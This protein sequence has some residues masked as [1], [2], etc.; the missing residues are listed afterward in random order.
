MKKILPLLILAILQY[1]CSEQKKIARFVKKNGPKQI[2]AHIAKEYPEYLKADTVRYIDTVITTRVVKVPQVYHDTIIQS[3][4]IN[5]CR[6][7]H[8]SDRNLLFNV[9]ASKVNYRIFERM[10]H[11]TAI[12]YI[13]KIIPCPPCPTETVV[14]EV[15]R[16]SEIEKS[17]NEGKLSFYSKGFWGLM[18]LLL[19]IIGYKVLKISGKL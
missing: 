10:F 17:K 14:Q 11:D 12:V 19:I 4:T 18:I 8:Y 7:F 9:M 6:E 13:D 3:D 2:A 16:Q 15:V 5:D 1:S